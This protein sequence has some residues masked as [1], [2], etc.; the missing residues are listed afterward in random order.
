MWLTSPPHRRNLLAPRW[1][2]LGIAYEEGHIFGRDG[3]GLWVLQ[4]GRR[5]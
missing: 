1:R 3:V 5:V 2:D 4:L